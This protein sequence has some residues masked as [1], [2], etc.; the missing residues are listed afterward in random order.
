MSNCVS[1]DKVFYN[2]EFLSFSE[3]SAKKSS[4]NDP[5]EEFSVL[6]DIH[7]FNPEE[8]IVKVLQDQL[9]I[10][11]KYDEMRDDGHGL[12]LRH[13]VRKFKLPKDI[14]YNAFTSSISVDGI[15]T[16]KAPKLEKLSANERQVPIQYS[17]VENAAKKTKI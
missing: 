9:I 4:K 15:L 3:D 14:D 12:I 13:F 8:V 2:I 1:R 6:I 10:E 7:T 11:G 16:V 17:G 5:E